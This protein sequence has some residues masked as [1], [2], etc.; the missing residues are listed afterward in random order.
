MRRL[1][2]KVAVIIG[3]GQSP[4]E[5]IGNGRATT[6]RFAQEGARILAADINPQSAQES[7]DL[8]NVPGLDGLSVGVDTSKTDTVHA[9]IDAAYARWGRIDILHYN[10]GIS[11]MGGPQSIEE[12]GDEAFDKVTDVNLRGAVMACK[13]V[14]PIMREQAS[15]AINLVS[16]MSAIETY[17]AHVG[18]RTSKAGMISYMQLVAMHYAEFGV[19]CNAILPGRM[20]TAMAVDTRMRTTGRSREDL[21]AERNSMVPLR[22]RGGTGWDIANAALFLASEEANFITGVALPVDGGTLVK[23]GW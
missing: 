12:I 23:I 14:L 15:G 3:A 19:R 2:D 6:M 22:K 9:A 17:T 10:V 5:E 8:A 18:Y 16:S 1:E 20:Q 13:Y 7:L 11:I 4:G 21:I